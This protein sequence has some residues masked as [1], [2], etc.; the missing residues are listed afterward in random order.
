MQSFCSV[1]AAGDGTEVAREGEEEAVALTPRDE[2]ILEQL[3]EGSVEPDQLPVEQQKRLSQ[4]IEMMISM[5]EMRGSEH[6][7]DVDVVEEEGS[8]ERALP[9]SEHNPIATQEAATRSEDDDDDDI[10]DDLVVK[11]G[12]AE[13]GV[14]NVVDSVPITDTS[15]NDVDDK[16]EPDL[17]LEKK[18]PPSG[19]DADENES[20]NTAVVKTKYTY[21]K[22]NSKLDESQAKSFVLNL[23]KALHVPPGVASLDQ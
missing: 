11:G 4:F 5:L 19:E 21:I 3:L 13:D 8:E 10:S 6:H 14:E 12:S 18:A 17:S 2:E 9:P 7:D 15:D 20:E 22:L 23:T 1:H 16:E